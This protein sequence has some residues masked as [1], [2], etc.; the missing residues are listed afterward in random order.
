MSDKILQAIITW[1]DQGW[2]CRDIALK[3]I[4]RIVNAPGDRGRMS[5]KYDEWQNLAHV[6]KH[7]PPCDTLYR[8]FQHIPRPMIKS[9]FEDG[10]FWR[11]TDVATSA[12]QWLQSF[13]DPTL[14]LAAFWR[15]EILPLAARLRSPDPYN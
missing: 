2:I 3:C 7:C 11:Y 9:Y 14:E 6:L 4:R 1:E 10:A 5:I 12:S 13:G 15:P 8:E